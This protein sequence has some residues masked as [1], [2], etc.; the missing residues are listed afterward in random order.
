MPADEKRAPKAYGGRYKSKC[1]KVREVLRLTAEN[2]ARL[3]MTTVPERGSLQEQKQIQN[4]YRKAPPPRASAQPL[5]K[6]LGARIRAYPSRTQGR[7]VAGTKANP[8]ARRLGSQ[9]TQ[10]SVCARIPSGLVV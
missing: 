9:A 3:R 1:K 4:A 6:L 2:A 7:T 8:G 10:R 5:A